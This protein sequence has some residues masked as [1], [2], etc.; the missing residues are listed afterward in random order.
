MSALRAGAKGNSQAPMKNPVLFFMFAA[1]VLQH[2]SG[3]PLPA[4]QRDPAVEIYGLTGAYH[5]ANRAH[6]L[7]GGEWN[8]QAA[9]GVLFPLGSRWAVLADGVTSRLEVNQGLHG[10]H[11]DHPYSEFYR[12]NPD[13]QNEDITTQRLMAV[14]PSIVRLWR[15]DRFSIYLGGGFG[16]EHQRQLIRYRP[17]REHPDGSGLLVRD[18]GFVDSRDSVLATPLLFRGGLL[19]N[20]TPRVVLRGGYSHILGYLDT[21]ASRSLEVGIGFRF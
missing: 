16:L 7:K 15:R 4:Q 12:V 11:D 18:E 20:L 9:V 3:V 2:F 13:V 1:A 6:S 10:P 21:P 17:I 8:P 14:L 19:V 5:F